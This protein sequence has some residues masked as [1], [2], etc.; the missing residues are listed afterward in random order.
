MRLVGYLQLASPLAG[1]DIGDVSVITFFI[2]LL[3]LPSLL[4]RSFASGI[5]D[6]PSSSIVG[7]GHSFPSIAWAKSLGMVQR[8]RFVILGF[9]SVGFLARGTEVMGLVMM[10]CV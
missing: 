8:F 3:F 9:Q 5:W 6:I 4:G 1:D 10:L 7:S 2:S